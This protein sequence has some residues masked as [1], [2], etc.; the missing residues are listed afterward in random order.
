M[1]ISPSTVFQV[2]NTATAGNVNGGGFN[3]ANANGIADGVIASGTGGSPT[4]T[5]AA[6][7]FV[8]GDVN[9]WIYFKTQTNMI[10]GWYQI[11]SVTTGVAT[12]SAAIGQAQIVTN[13]RF[14]TN[15]SAGCATTTA[16]TGVTYLVDYSQSD[17]A[18]YS[19]S[20]LTGATTSATDATNPFTTQMVGNHR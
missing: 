17:V 16:P 18:R 4:L 13:N 15:A 3:P 11:A 8:A 6:Y 10:A 19:N 9:H 14:G 20:A 1:A 5:T 7:T 2:Q 12:L